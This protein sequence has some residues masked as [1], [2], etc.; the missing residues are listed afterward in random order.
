MDTQ[1]KIPLVAIVDDDDLVRGALQG[2]LKSVGVPA[3]AFAA[4]DVRK[5]RREVTEDS[6]RS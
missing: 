3:R 1:A 2:L 4:T 6:Q 5:S